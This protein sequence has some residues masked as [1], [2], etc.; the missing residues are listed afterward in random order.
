[1]SALTRR[2]ALGAIAAAPLAAPAFLA[3]LARPAAANVPPPVGRQAP[4]WFRF[5]VGQAEV[6]VLHDGYFIRPN[7][8][9]GM[10]RNATGEQVLGELREMFLP[11]DAVHNPFN[12]TV[13]NTGRNLVLFDAGNGTAA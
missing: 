12:I 5:K 6:T 13:V 3:G 11:T 8:A 1:M 9:D 2:I 10:V 7:P 4:G